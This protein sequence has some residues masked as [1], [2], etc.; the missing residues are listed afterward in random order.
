MSRHR[1]RLTAAPMI[2]QRPCSMRFCARY[3][4]PIRAAAAARDRRA[5]LD[6]DLPERKLKLKPDGSVDK[7]ITPQRLD[8]HRLIEE[9]MILA[10]VAAAETLERAGSLLIYRVH[11]E[12]SLEKMRALGEILASVQIKLTAQRPCPPCPVQP[13]SGPRQR[14]APCAAA[15]RND[16]AHAGTG[17][18][19]RRKLRPFRLEFAPLRSFHITD[20]PVCG[21][22]CASRPRHRQSLW[23]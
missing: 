9:F 3:G 10:N 12:P 11:D 22:G 5:P 21:S 16:F 20:P 7:V 6:L 19:C 15:Q 2:K 13:N 1:P 14:Y 8:A 4:L 18:I 17:G 23:W